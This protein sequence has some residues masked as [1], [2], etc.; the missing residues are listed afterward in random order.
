MLKRKYLLFAASLLNYF[1]LSQNGL[2]LS[3]P[4]GQ[5]D[6]LASS[7]QKFSPGGEKDYHRKMHIRHSKVCQSVLEWGENV[8]TAGITV[9][10]FPL[11]VGS[12]YYPET[13]A[14]SLTCQAHSFSLPK[15][16]TMQVI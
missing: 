7:M 16:T 3:E 8:F 12:D 11:M 15:A 4:A 13:E 9:T 6:W 14:V 10:T 5:C 2:V 1:F